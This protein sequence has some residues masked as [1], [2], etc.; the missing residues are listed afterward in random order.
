MFVNDMPDE[1][2]RKCGGMLK[3]CSLCAECRQA[4]K[5]IC[6]KCGSLTIDVLHVNCFYATE[7]IQ[8]T[9]QALAPVNI[10]LVMA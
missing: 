1:S 6:V 9:R 3:R 5:H 8:E 4:T 7:S 2:C 10:G